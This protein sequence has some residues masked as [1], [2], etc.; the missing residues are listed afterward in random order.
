MGKP[1]KD[2]YADRKTLEKVFELDKPNEAEFDE[3]ETQN[4]L[5]LLK[6]VLKYEPGERPEVEEVL[7]HVWF[8]SERV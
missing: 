6:W 5:Y 3:E 4:V 1:A 8:K 2:K 7:E